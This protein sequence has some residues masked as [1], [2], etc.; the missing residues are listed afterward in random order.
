[1]G[2]NTTITFRPLIDI[3]FSNGS[4]SQNFSTFQ[5]Q[6]VGA[7]NFTVCEDPV[8]I[9]Y[10][11]ISFRD[12]TTGTIRNG[13]ILSSSFVHSLNSNLDVFKT[14]NYV[15][16]SEPLSHEFCFDPAPLPLFMNYSLVYSALDSEQRSFS[17][18]TTFSN[19]TTNLTLDLLSTTSGLFVTFQVINV[20]TEPL[21][22]VEVTVEK[23]GVVVEKRI[24]DDAGGVTFFLDP[25]T[26]YT[27]TFVKPGFTT[28]IQSIVPSQSQF[29]VTMGEVETVGDNPASG[30][31]YIVEPTLASLQNETNYNFNLTVNSTFFIIQSI[32]FNLRNST[33]TTILGFA[34]CTGTTSSCFAQTTIN[35]GKNSDIVMELFWEVN[36]TFANAT[37][38]WSVSSSFKGVSS[39]KAFFED[40]GKLG[41]GFDNFTRAMISIF[42]IVMFTGIVTARVGFSSPSVILVTLTMITGFLDAARFLPEIAGTPRFFITIIMGII[43]FAFIFFE[44]TR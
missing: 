33:D 21:Q 17:N 26:L 20:A 2:D 4:V 7:I 37:R 13:S 36:D 31:V 9:P 23:N 22:G 3:H 18:Q 14:F 8:L 32:G 34:T 43:T 28:L 19:E 25:N 29:T 39:F 40:I 12:E 27:F 44:F 11:N 15:N 24:T 42:V 35:T 5:N 41:S 10:L 6:D 30:L 38:T 16:T 1:M